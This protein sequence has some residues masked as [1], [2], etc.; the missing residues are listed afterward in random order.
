VGDKGVCEFGNAVSNSFLGMNA[1]EN[2][3]VNPP[4]IISGTGSFIANGGLHPNRRITISCSLS[5]QASSVIYFN[6]AALVADIDHIT[7]TNPTGING[8]TAVG[9]KGAFVPGF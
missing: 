3:Y 2:V 9:T 7:L 1:G 6:L 5:L 4:G 8:E